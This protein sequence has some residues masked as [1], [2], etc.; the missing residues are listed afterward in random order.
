MPAGRSSHSRGRRARYLGHRRPWLRL[1]AWSCA[2]HPW[3]APAIGAVHLVALGGIAQPIYIAFDLILLAGG[4]ALLWF[5]A[6]A[7]LVRR[8]A[9]LVPTPAE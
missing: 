3:L 5:Y 6:R 9:E 2:H 7:A 4:G 1:L 8:D